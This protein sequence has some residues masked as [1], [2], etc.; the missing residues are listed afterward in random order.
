VAAPTENE[1]AM[2][3]ERIA[4]LTRAAAPRLIVADELGLVSHVDEALEREL[5]WP[6]G[7]LVGRPLTAI[8]PPRFRD[9]H[10]IGF[11]RFLS[12]K[13]PVLLDRPLSFVVLNGR[14]EELAAEHFITATPTSHG[15]L[16]ASSI[17]LV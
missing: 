6:P 3:R 11:A 14:G 15:W 12:T 5:G 16:F 8:I 10:H 2:L 13:T 1:L 9:A 4:E 7:E 17:R